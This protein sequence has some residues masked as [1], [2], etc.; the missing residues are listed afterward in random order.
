MAAVGL[1]LLEP[2]QH[3]EAIVRMSLHPGRLRGHRAR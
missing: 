3:D 1:H 2:E